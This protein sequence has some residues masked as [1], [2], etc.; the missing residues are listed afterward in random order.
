MEGVIVLGIPDEQC[1]RIILFFSGLY[2]HHGGVWA[3]SS[4]ALSNVTNICRGR[5]GFSL[6]VSPGRDSLYV[7]QPSTYFKPVNTWC[8]SLFLFLCIVWVRITAYC[9]QLRGV[10]V[11]SGVSPRTHTFFLLS[12]F[13]AGERYLP[14]SGNRSLLV[15]SRTGQ[16][17]QQQGKFLSQPSTFR[18]AGVTTTVLHPLPGVTPVRSQ[19]SV[20]SHA[21]F[22]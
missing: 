18:N 4:S 11:A 9:Q 15:S 21:S 10:I 16:H 20:Q 8:K 5:P 12:E 14:N 19:S 17:R 13:H 3:P 6:M 22:G 1:D 7:S 2:P